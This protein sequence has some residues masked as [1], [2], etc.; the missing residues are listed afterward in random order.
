[1]KELIRG[2]VITLVRRP[3]SSVLTAAGI[4]IGTALVILIS[5]I[6][7]IGETMIEKELQ[8]MGIDGLSVSASDGLT[9]Q[10][11]RAE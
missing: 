8:N 7:S 1:M 10:C 2:A 4:A 6:S 9:G 11:L 3:L 5:C